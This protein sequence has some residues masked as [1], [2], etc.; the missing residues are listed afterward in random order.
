MPGTPRDIIARLHEGVVYALKVPDT[1]KRFLSSGAE[2][3]GNTPEAF[4]A[5]IRSDM[6]KWAKV[7][8]AAGIKPE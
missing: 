2:P 8:K 3:V 7:I 4:A 6:A 1:R 5:V